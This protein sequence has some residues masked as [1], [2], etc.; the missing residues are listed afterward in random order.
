M[1][2]ELLG[3]GL[4]I[5]GWNYLKLEQNRSVHDLI[6]KSHIHR[7]MTPLVL[8]NTLPKEHRQEANEAIVACLEAKST[9]MPEWVGK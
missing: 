5:D 7:Q 2:D 4:D 6:D 1:A 3:G 8:R 9:F